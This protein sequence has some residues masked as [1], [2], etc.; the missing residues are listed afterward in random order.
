MTLSRFAVVV[1][2][3]VLAATLLL[4]VLALATP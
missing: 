3:A 4:P 1:A 2:A